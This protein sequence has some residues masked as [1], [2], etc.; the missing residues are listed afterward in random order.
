MKPRMSSAS[1]TSLVV[2]VGIPLFT[3]CV[4]ADDEK[5][6]RPEIQQMI[7]SVGEK[8]LAAADR[9][10][11]TADQRSKIRD[12]NTGYAEKRKSLRTERH[13]LLQEELKALGTILTPE[14][15]EKAKEL[16]E[17]RVEEVKET[18]AQ[19]LPVFDG[20][21]DTLAER[22]ESAAEKLGLNSEQREKIVKTL[23][24]HADHHAALRAKCRE[25]CKEE[26]K[27]VAAVLTPEQRE[28]AREYIERRIV[29]ARAVKSVADRLEAA[30]DKLGLSADQRQQIEKAHSQFAGRYR[31][32]R[33]ERRQLLREE[34]KTI[35]PILTQEQREMVK[36]FWEDRV[37]IKEGAA[38]G[39]EPIEAAGALKET[40]A[41][42]LEAVA[43]KLGL[44]ADQRT[45]IRAARD[46]FAER[47]KAQR[48]TRRALRQEE[49]KALGGILTAQQRD[50]VKEFVEDHSEVL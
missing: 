31:E 35:A 14:Q 13:A 43:N 34:L 45:E 48:D 21:R 46:S 4:R 29:R 42:R 6:L 17:D 22:V 24:S 32:L 39:R 20:E 19:G 11:L 38:S 28:K 41:E 2:I 7:Q 44:T 36:D 1:V 15:R 9:L 5:S 23:A 30:A 40:I 18:R 8:L 16:V 3:A 37:A 49:L 26:F 33:S 25:I 47:F 50:K 10:E 27:D 12:I